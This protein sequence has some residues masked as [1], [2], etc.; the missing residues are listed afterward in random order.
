[1]KE[2]AP[3][4]E[5]AEERGRL[6]K[7]A[8]DRRAPA[9]EACK[10]IDNFGQAELKMIKYVETNSAKCGIPPQIADQLRS[11]HKNTE[12]MQSRSVR[13]R[14]WPRRGPEFGAGRRHAA[15][16]RRTGWGLRSLDQQASSM[17][18]LRV[19]SACK[20]RIGHLFRSDSYAFGLKG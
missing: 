1:M 18:R 8:S 17:T 14:N 12:K 10:L 9:D 7:A 19:A 4:R 2:F 13:A 20:S 6:I 15:R 16:A 11:G 5:A 3:L